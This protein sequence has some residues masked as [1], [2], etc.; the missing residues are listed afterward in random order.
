M[1]E[2][3]LPPVAALTH[4]LHRLLAH[5]L[6]TF[7]C[8]TSRHALVPTDCPRTRATLLTDLPCRHAVPLMTRFD[9]LVLAARQLLVAR[10]ATAEALLAA[11]DRPSLLVAPVAPLGRLQHAGRTHRTRVAVVQNRMV[12]H[13]APL[14]GLVA[15]GLLGAAGNGRVEHLGAALTLQLV[16]GG[17]LA[18]KAVP[19]VAGSLAFVLAATERRGTGQWTDVIDVDAALDVALVLSAAPLLCAL[20]LATGIVGSRGQLPAFHLKKKEIMVKGGSCEVPIRIG[21]DDKLK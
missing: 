15:G 18:G 9:A 3:V 6:G 2:P 1:A 13:V 5:R 17:P 20:F 10:H 11:R 8:V 4:H 21:E 16:E 19:R 14:A 12:T 7:A